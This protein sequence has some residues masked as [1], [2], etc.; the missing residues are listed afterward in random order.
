MPQHEQRLES[1]LTMLG[2][3]PTTRTRRVVSRPDSVCGPAP[4]HHGKRRFYETQFAF[5][6]LLRRDNQKVALPDG[7]PIF[8]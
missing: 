3:S 5:V 6:L 7:L 2:D 8:L 4:G 1:S